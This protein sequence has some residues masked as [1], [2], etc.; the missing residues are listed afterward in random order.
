MAKYHEHDSWDGETNAPSSNFTYD[1]ELFRYLVW[2]CWEEVLSHDADGDVRSGSVEALATAFS[3]GCAVRVGVSGLCADLS[4][5]GLEHEVF[6]ETGSCYYYLD[7]RVFIAGSHPVVRV[8]PGIPLRY[9][10]KGWD[11]GWLLLRTDGAVVYRRCD[12]YTLGFDDRESKC[13]IRWLVR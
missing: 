6:V 1:F 5:S 7:Q 4:E 2:D 8:S 10:S 9:E 12:P 13:A 11:F 3:D